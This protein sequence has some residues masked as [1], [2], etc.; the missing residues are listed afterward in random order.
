ML[1]FN[2]KEIGTEVLDEEITIT[3]GSIGLK[4]DN[5]INDSDYKIEL[6][7]GKNK[8]GTKL[9]ENLDYTLHNYDDLYDAYNEIEFTSDCLSAHNLKT[10]YASYRSRGDYIDASDVNNKEDKFEKRSAFNKDF[11]TGVD[12]VSRGNHEHFDYERRF[13][14]RTAFNKDYGRV[15]GTV[16]EGNHKHN[17]L[18][19]PRIGD[20]GNAFNKSFGTIA[21][22][23]AE[24]NHTHALLPTISEKEAMIGTSGTPGYINRFVTNADYRLINSRQPIIHNIN[25]YHTGVLSLSKG[26]TGVTNY[27][28]LRNI[29]NAAHKVHSHN[30]ATTSGAGFMSSTQ[31]QKL[32]NISLDFVNRNLFNE[33][34]VIG[35]SGGSGTISADQKNDS[36]TFQSIDSRIVLTSDI[37]E[38]KLKFAFSDE[39]LLKTNFSPQ[40][41]ETRVSLGFVPEGDYDLVPKN[42]VDQKVDPAFLMSLVG[43]EPILKTINPS[44]TVELDI[45]EASESDFVEWYINAK[46]GTTDFLQGKIMSAFDGND[47]KNSSLYSALVKGNALSDLSISSIKKVEGGKTYIS[48][49]VINNSSKTYNTTTYRSGKIFLKA[50]WN[51]IDPQ[52]ITN[53]LAVNNG[54]TNN[55][56]FTEG[57]PVVSYGSYLG[58]GLVNAEYIA[59]TTEKNFV[60]LTEKDNWNNKQDSFDFGVLSGQVPKMSQNA[61]NGN[62]AIF[63]SGGLSSANSNEIKNWLGLNLLENKDYSNPVNINQ[64]SNYR[65]VTDA[66]KTTWNSKEDE[67]PSNSGIESDQRKYYYLN[68]NKEWEDVKVKAG[69]IEGKIDI[70]NLP[71]GALPIVY[72]VTSEAGMLALTTTEVKNGDTVRINYSNGDPDDLYIVV[73]ES[74]LG[75]LT[76]ADAFSKYNSNIDW[77]AVSNKVNSSLISDGILTKEDYKKIDSLVK[78]DNV[79]YTASESNEAKRIQLKIRANQIESG[80]INIDRLPHETAVV[81]NVPVTQTAFFDEILVSESKYCEW[82]IYAFCDSNNLLK[83]KV[84]ATYDGSAILNTTMHSVIKKGTAQDDINPVFSFSDNKIKLS[85]QNL[86]TGKQYEVSTTKTN[87]LNIK[88]SNVYMSPSEVVGIL[89]V[90][91]GGTNNNSFTN[92]RPIKFQTS[93]L[94]SGNISANYVDETT[95]KRFLTATERENV[96]NH[97]SIYNNPHQ[98]TK[99]QIGL[100]NVQNLDQRNASNISSGTISQSV[101]PIVQ[102]SKGGTGL[103][104]I[105]AGYYL[106]GKDGASL[107]SVSVATVKSDLNISSVSGTVFNGVNISKSGTGSNSNLIIHDGKTLTIKD[108]VVIDNNNRVPEIS[109]TPDGKILTIKSGKASW[110]DAPQTGIANTEEIQINRLKNWD[111][112]AN[113]PESFLILTESGGTKGIIGKQSKNEYFSYLTSHTGGKLVSYDWA[114]S[115]KY[116]GSDFKLKVGQLVAGNGSGVG[117]EEKIPE[118]LLPRMLPKI[119]NKNTYNDMLSMTSNEA[120]PGDT[121]L[122]TNG[123]MYLVVADINPSQ[124]DPSASFRKYSTSVSWA[125][126]SGKINAGYSPETGTPSSYTNGLM[127][128]EDKYKLDNIASTLTNFDASVI[129]TGTIDIERLP[130]EPITNKNIASGQTILFSEISTSETPFCDFGIYAVGTAGKVLKGK[131]EIAYGNGTVYKTTIHSVINQNNALNDI[132][133]L[134]EYEASTA[135]IKIKIKNNHSQA[136]SVWLYKNN[137]LHFKPSNIY[138][139]PSDVSGI[140]NT[141]NGGTN[142]DTYTENQP[143]AYRNIGGNYKITSGNIST[144]YLDETTDKAFVT[145]TQRSDYD[146]HINNASKHRVINDSSTSSEDLW[147]AHRINSA[148][149][150][151]VNVVSGWG[152]SQNNFTTDEKNKLLNIEANAKNYTHPLSHAPS[153]INQDSDNRFVTDV[154]KTTWSA[155]QNALGNGDVTLNM[156]A[157]LAAK[158]LIGNNADESATPAALG[159]S[160][161]REMIFPS[162]TLNNDQSAGTVLTKKDGAMNWSNMPLIPILTNNHGLTLMGTGT[163]SLSWSYAGALLPVLSGNKISSP[164]SSDAGKVLVANSNATSASW[165][166]IDALP[167]QDEKGGRFLKT[168][169]SSAS[170]EEIDIEGYQ[171]AGTGT[172]NT[173]IGRTIPIGKTLANSDYKVCITPTSNPLGYLGEYWVDSK[174]NTTFVVKNSGSTTTATFDWVI[175]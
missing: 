171:A 99:A 104:N 157:N 114:D 38:K 42:Y 11:G 13:L 1:L 117:E 32:N 125:N 69:N 152:L 75:G 175:I 33:I 71:E 10:F 68:S 14:K 30:V 116:V 173:T 21:G 88:P 89:P 126:V 102:V 143:L 109:T 130:F 174:T 7:S 62:V 63:S 112:D 131:I 70:I 47:V 79:T 119:V 167:D 113:F 35:A 95:S 124:S 8:T 94:I 91:N 56:S 18:Y 142:N 9:L 84:E 37:D 97:V 57:M 159:V 132:E 123:D 108:D 64:T 31:V 172:F 4:H 24:G 139:D 73:D 23:V 61:T 147:S 134:F 45:V 154:E 22:S 27:D 55:S 140:L 83:G 141:A 135:K 51:Y 121:V 148:L 66:E 92:D 72:T 85:I 28:T 54:G 6:Y 46:S 90:A 41:I 50:S 150:T 77:S 162:T 26:G 2:Y 144:Q 168:D 133:A 59:S 76:P 80:I 67:L 137:K 96:L 34:D 82:D 25:D 110:E 129:K 118:E 127:L 151:K 87:R 16:S 101:L 163:S 164:N 19:E 122:L 15:E 29:I 160:D 106:K 105:S 136:Y 165:E 20:H 86:S 17:E 53:I 166:E 48:L 153:I 40:V 93:K 170:W 12:E 78:S 146:S 65:F 128:G 115:K 49:R 98:V 5:F 103:N 107:T 155:K 149:G 156:M 52:N 100:S 161:L 39:G 60:S 138:M 120:L 158:S 111:S 3:S 44:S 58:S 74:K 43:Q 36:L 81:K 169:G 145:Q